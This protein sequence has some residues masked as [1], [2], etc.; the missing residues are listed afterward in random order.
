MDFDSILLART[1][2]GGGGGG[3]ATLI[4]KNISSNGT[5][6]ASS[7]S[8]DGYKKVVVSVPN[9]YVAGDE[10]KVVSSGALVSQT[11][12]T[13]TTNNTYDTTL[14]NSVTVN[15]SS[16][17]TFN[18]TGASGKLWGGMA[19]AL[20]DGTYASG[21]VTFTTAFTNTWQTLVNTGLTTLHGFCAWVQDMVY[22]KSSSQIGGYL[23]FSVNQDTTLDYFCL[24]VPTAYPTSMAGTFYAPYTQETEY[25]KAGMN[26]ALRLNGGVVE[27]RGRYNMNANYQILPANKVI[28]W[29]AW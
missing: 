8:A 2:E 13:Y 28:E 12:A 25:D 5:Y 4:D 3:E 15:V 16:G 17:A 9:T 22:T 21:N 29:I 1:L 14:V 18:F 10:G 26:G 23:I 19:K 7:D 6:N 24:D 27:Y 20:V 11:S